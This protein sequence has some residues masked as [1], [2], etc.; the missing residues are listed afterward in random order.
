MHSLAHVIINAISSY[1]K[2][3]VRMFVVAL[4]KLCALPACCKKWKTNGGI[5][6]HN[7]SPQFFILIF[8]VDVALFLLLSIDMIDCCVPD[9]M[10]L[11][12]CM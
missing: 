9:L 2:E 3:K 6:M 7:A 8:V 1:Q 5:I 12:C 10:V 11:V 4:F